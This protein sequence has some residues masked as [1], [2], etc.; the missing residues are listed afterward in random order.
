MAYKPFW[1]NKILFPKSLSLDKVIISNK[2]KNQTH[3]EKVFKVYK[4]EKGEE[5]INGDTVSRNSFIS[6]L[7]HM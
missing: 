5:F 7:Y 1:G 3:H 6:I 4:N 2:H